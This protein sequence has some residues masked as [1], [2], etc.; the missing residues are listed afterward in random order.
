MEAKGKMAR[1]KRE[2]VKKNDE[3]KLEKIDNS[4]MPE[5]RKRNDG[6]WEVSNWRVWTLWSDG[7]WIAKEPWTLQGS[8]TKEK[9]AKVE[10]QRAVWPWPKK[11]SEEGAEAKRHWLTRWAYYER[12]HGPGEEWTLDEYNPAEEE[13]QADAGER[14]EKQETDRPVD[15]GNQEEHAV[16][17]Q[18]DEN[19]A[20]EFSEDD[21]DVPLDQVI[22]RHEP[23][24]EVDEPV[25]ADFWAALPKRR[26]PNQEVI[27]ISSDEE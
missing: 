23:M 15:A 19:K 1:K 26:R 27:V 22:E 11:G 5:W 2:R 17:G 10:K 7:S 4:R 18:D 20:E 14:V 21:D 13:K 16:E 9:M 6:S 8:I 3:P 25:A 12:R 24:A